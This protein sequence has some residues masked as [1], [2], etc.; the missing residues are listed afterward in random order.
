MLKPVLLSGL[1]GLSL[2][3]FAI[4]AQAQSQGQIYQ[5]QIQSTASPTIPAL[6]LQ[7]FVQVQKRWKGIEQQSQGLMVQAIKS[8]GLTPERF[9][10]ILKQ[11][12]SPTPSDDPLSTDDN[13][14]FEKIIA[15][16][17]KIEEESIPK[18][19]KAII[20]QGL[21][22]QRFGQIQRTI[23]QDPALQEKVKKMLGEDAQ[24]PAKQP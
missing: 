4:A 16:F 10:A 6:E 17:Q 18:K 1:V 14:K 15:K 7:Q 8:E 2:V 21:D 23:Q 5:A 24:Q 3:S 12:Q 11:K 13:T 19:E 20:S 9:M 22:I